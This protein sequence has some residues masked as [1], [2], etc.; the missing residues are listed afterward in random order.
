MRLIQIV[1]CMLLIKF[2]H[3]CSVSGGPRGCAADPGDNAYCKCY[4]SGNG[5]PGCY[6]GCLRFLNSKELLK[7]DKPENIDVIMKSK[8]YTDYLNTSLIVNKTII[9]M[10]TCSVSYLCSIN[11]PSKYS[12]LCSSGGCI[13]VNVCKN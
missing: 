12:A 1:V 7:L 10:S 5:M 4:I 2:I 13:C 8:K 6:C 11:C 9:P 3:N